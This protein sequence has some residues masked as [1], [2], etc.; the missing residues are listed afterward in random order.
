MTFKK[1]LFMGLLGCTILAGCNG[2]DSANNTSDDTA[3][4][5]ADLNA[6]IDQPDYTE[7][8]AKELPGVQNI[9]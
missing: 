8:T 4:T 5:F 3:T 7:P 2:S 6:R 1:T 9:Q